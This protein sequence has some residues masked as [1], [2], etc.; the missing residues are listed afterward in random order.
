MREGDATGVDV[1]VDDSGAAVGVA[2][3]SL[4]VCALWADPLGVCAALLCGL[5]GVAV[6]VAVG[7]GFC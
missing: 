7:V 2:V 3:V 1:T 4:L 5:V 6:G